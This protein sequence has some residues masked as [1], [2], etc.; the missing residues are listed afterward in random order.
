MT[1]DGR[2][3]GTPSRSDARDTYLRSPRALP[4]CARELDH[5]AAA[6]SARVT[7]AA[8][9]LGT[10]VEI[11]R[12]PGRCIV[13]LGPVALTLSW[14]RDRVDTV[15]DGCLLVNEWDGVVARG[16]VPSPERAPERAGR[17][18]KMIHETQLVAD[19]TEEKDWR[20]REEK[21]G[22]AHA[23]QELATLCVDSLVAGFRARAS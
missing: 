3:L 12:A 9:E 15:A 23:S 11:R 13:Q 2:V 19:A 21:N 6:V 5:L 7:A 14:V 16:V 8:A 17:T 4:A 10:T 1:A 22:E 20:W 18:A